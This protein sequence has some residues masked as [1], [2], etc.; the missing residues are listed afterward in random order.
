MTAAVKILNYVLF[1][2]LF[3]SKF[4]SLPELVSQGILCN[5]QP[6]K[7][8]KSKQFE[9]GIGHGK[10]AFKNA[11]AKVVKTILKKIYSNL[12]KPKVFVY[13]RPD[14]AQVTGQDRAG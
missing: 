4:V 1:R 9:K 11:R 14:F 7:T 6:R 5:E 2:F 8:E 13:L 3:N 12:G 10:F